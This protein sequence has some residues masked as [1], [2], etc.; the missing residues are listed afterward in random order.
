MD[1]EIFLCRCCLNSTNDMID[2]SSP[3]N[4][5]QSTNNTILECLQSSTEIQTD[6][7]DSV[8]MPQTICATC[9]DELKVTVEF[10]RKCSRS[11]DILRKQFTDQFIEDTLKD[12]DSFVEGGDNAPNDAAANCIDSSVKMESA[13]DDDFFDENKLKSVATAR[14]S[15]DEYN[16]VSSDDGTSVETQ[17][18]ECFSDD[19]AAESTVA[20]VSNKNTKR[21]P[22]KFDCHMCGRS[23]L[24]ANHLKIHFLIH[25]ENDGDKR[26]PNSPAEKYCIDSHLKN[27]A[28]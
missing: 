21:S 25:Q 8:T 27:N 14:Y 16:A 7:K 10:R 12:F 11:D 6:D 13:D 18:D 17:D 5:I 23:Y 1:I 26:R 24:N 22:K 20:S 15:F 3:M 4:E 28:T 9:Y 19:D 2:L